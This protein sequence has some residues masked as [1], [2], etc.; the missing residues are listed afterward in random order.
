MIRGEIDPQK[1]IVALRRFA[2]LTQEEFAEAMGISVS[3][4]AQLG[5]RAP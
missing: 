2:D 1:D 3:H 5:A 4:V